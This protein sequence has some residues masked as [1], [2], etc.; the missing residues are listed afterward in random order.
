MAA[1]QSLFNPQLL[2]DFALNGEVKHTGRSY[3]L[4]S[5][6]HLRIENQ[7]FLDLFFRGNA[8]D[9]ESRFG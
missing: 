9:R 5:F 3:G 6:E 1:R 4:W 8:R 7:I 2:V